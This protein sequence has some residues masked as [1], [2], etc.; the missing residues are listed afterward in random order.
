M[1]SKKLGAVQSD[2][3]LQLRRAREFMDD[4]YME[5]IDLRETSRIACLSPYHFLRM[6][7]HAFGETPHQYLTHRRIERAR[8][9]L[10]FSER[11]VTDIC[12][13]VGYE[14]LGSFS[15][16]FRKMIGDSPLSFRTR[17]VMPIVPQVP[18]CY[19]RM[20]GIHIPIPQK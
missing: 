19:L 2:V 6:F 9:L 17:V 7:R 1:K 10:L 12:F 4:C 15:T 20:W 5:A 18:A 14:S 8:E 11:S 16:L 3:F 13:D